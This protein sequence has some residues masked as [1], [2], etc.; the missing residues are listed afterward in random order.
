MHVVHKALCVLIIT[1][2]AFGAP[3][4]ASQQSLTLPDVN[5]T[6]P[7]NAPAAP[8]PP[9]ASGAPGN[10][11][12]GN[13][14]V[15]EDKWPD[16]PCGA[17]RIGLGEAGKCKKGPRMETFQTG[18]SQGSRQQSNCDITHDLV[19]GSAGSM[20]IEAEVLV[21]DPYYVSG[22]GHQ[23]Q[24]CYVHPVPGDLRVDFADMNR[25]TRQ[26]SGW[27]NFVESGDRVTMEFDVG[28]DR[29][30]AIEQRGPR[31]G[32]G[33]IYLIHAAVCRKDRQPVGP[34][35]VATVV[36]WLQVRQRNAIGNLNQ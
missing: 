1:A 22:I 23:R 24:D 10:P 7:G 20:T 16:I 4:V 18:D 32:G 30:A 19:M 26:G 12:F 27:R 9:R 13:Y 25:M 15:E 29:C 35:D 3:K 5:V 28:A 11:Y 14:R 31:W 2:A 33:Y 21:F 34:A 17:S 6:A 36:G 8:M